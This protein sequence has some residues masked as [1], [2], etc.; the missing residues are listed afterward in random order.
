M[1]CMVKSYDRNNAKYPNHFVF[2]DSVAKIGI[3]INLMDKMKKNMKG[4]ASR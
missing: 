3:K 4:T 2:C 1:F